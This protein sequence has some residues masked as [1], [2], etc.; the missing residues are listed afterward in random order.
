MLVIPFRNSRNYCCGKSLR[1]S[2]NHSFFLARTDR[3]GDANGGEGGRDDL[4]KGNWGRVARCNAFGKSFPPGDMPLV[5]L[6]PRTEHLFATMPHEFQPAKVVE[7][8]HTA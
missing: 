4:V 1:H 2:G 5:L 8:R 3:V 7:D 6:E